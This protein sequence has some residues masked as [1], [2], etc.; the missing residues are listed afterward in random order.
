MAK[1]SFQVQNHLE[2]SEHPAGRWW[3]PRDGAGVSR[4]D[5][6]EALSLGGGLSASGAHCVASREEE[7]R[8]RKRQ[9][10]GRPA[11]KELGGG[12]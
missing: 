1:V 11:G 7:R 3:G 2:V 4:G 10:A 5:S 6:G 9:R 12:E 8:K